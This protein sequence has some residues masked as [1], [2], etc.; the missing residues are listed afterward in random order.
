MDRFFGLDKVS[1]HPDNFELL[2]TAT[3]R[4]QLAIIE[5]IL[6][7]AKIRYISK[8]RGSGAAVKVIAGFSIFGS[9][10]FVLKEDLEKASAL[11]STSKCEESD[12]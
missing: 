4:V 1:S 2:I 3:D 12:D 9:D 6:K 8:D 11:I 7:E 10:V 5:S